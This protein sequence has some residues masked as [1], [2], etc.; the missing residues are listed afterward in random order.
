LPQ[1]T[2]VQR[3]GYAAIM[4]ALVTHGKM[5]EK[6][7]AAFVVEHG[8]LR[9]VLK[10]GRRNATKDWKVVKN[11][12]DRVMSARP[13]SDERDAFRYMEARIAIFLDKSADIR[14]TAIFLLRTALRPKPVG[15]REVS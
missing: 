10:K 15:D 3:G 14:K 1:E 11:W 5:T 7:A 9:Q 2:A 13:P 12:Y 4:N 6:E 8:G